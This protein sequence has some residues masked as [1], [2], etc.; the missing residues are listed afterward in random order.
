M[1]RIVAL[2]LGVVLTGVAGLWAADSGTV[3]E[4]SEQPILVHA[5]MCESIEEQTPKNE[6]II[7]SVSAR[8]ATCFTYFNPVPK[9]TLV[10]HNWYRQDRLSVKVKLRLRSPSWST[11]SRH[12]IR[13]SDKGPWRVEVTGEDGTIYAVLRFSI[14]D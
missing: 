9:N 2:I 13:A 12:R 1:A 3:E 11:F 7:F 10:Y 6:T 14:T 8:D 5:V 4:P